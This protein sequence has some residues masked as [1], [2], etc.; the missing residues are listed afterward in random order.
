M[1]LLAI[2]MAVLWTSVNTQDRKTIIEN[3]SGYKMERAPIYMVMTPNVVRPN[4]VIQV[5]ATI[6]RMND[7]PYLDVKVSI[8]Q[9][10]VAY[11]EITTK[12]ERPGSRLMQM[13]MP[14]NSQKGHYRLRVEG[15]VGDSGNVFFNESD[16]GFDSKQASV[17]IQLSKPI[18]RQG[19]NVS[20]RVL[21]IKQNMMPKYGSMTIYVKDPTGYPVRRWLAVQTNAGGIV[22]QSFMLSDQPNYGNWSIQV[23]GYGFTYYKYF[24]VEEFW[25]PRFDVNVTV[26]SYMMENVKTV[27]GIIMANMTTGKPIEGNAS[28]L[29]TVTEPTP[30][31]TD[32]FGN[33]NNVFVNNFVP[34]TF[35]IQKAFGYVNGPINFDF[36]MDEIRTR[37]RSEFGLYNG[38]DGV[39]LRFNA[40]VYD[41]FF[42]MTRSGYAST[43]LFKS[44]VKLQ[45]VGDRVRTF[46][47]DSVLTVQVAVM[48]YDGTP[49]SSSSKVRLSLS[50]TYVTSG[51][52]PY[53]ASAKSPSGGIA[54]FQITMDNA[55]KSLT[56]QATWEGDATTPMIDMMAY[57]FYSP[58]NRYI[59]LST[60]TKNPKVNT[61]MLFHVKT[62]LYVPRIYYQ[63]VGGGNILVG[64]ELEMISR[65]KSFAIALSRDMV[66]TARVVVYYLS[67]QPEEIVVDS[68]TFFVDGTG[69]NKVGA[70]VNRG[71]DFTRDTVEILATA[72]KGAY[73]AFAAIPLDLYKR[74]LNDGLNHW[75]IIDELNTYDSGRK[76]WQHLW[77]M[78]EVE[79]Q[80]K[81]YTASGHGIDANTTFRD[82]G[83][84]VMSDLT[85]NRVPVTSTELKC[86]ED[87]EYLPCFTGTSCYHINDTCNM[88]KTCTQDWADEQNCPMEDPRHN[89]LTLNMINRVSRVL[90][91]YEDSSWAWKETFTKPDGEVDFRV[92]VPK[93]PLTWVIHGAS[94]SRDTGLGIQPKPIQYDATRYMYIIVECPEHIIRG[95]Q[96][97]VRVT[98]FNYWFGDEF[99]EV[100]VTMEGSP[101][102]DSVLVGDEGF[103]QSYAPRR[104]NGDHQTIVFLEPGESKDIFMPIVPNMVQ[105]NLTFT[106]SAWCFLERDIVS[107]TIY[108]TSDGVENFYHTPYLIDM[109]TSGSM[110]IPDLKVNV[111]DQFIV[112]EQRYH[113]YV[114]GS[115]KGQ[116]TVFGDVVTPGFFREFPTA[117]D[118]L[119]RPYGS[120]EMN[121][122]NFAYNLLTLKFKKANQ[123]LSNDVLQTSLK[124]M[125]IALQRQMGYMN[126]DGSFRMFRDDHKPSVWLTAFV[127][128]TLFQAKFGEWEK[129]FFIPLELINKM[130]LW[131]CSQQHNVTG[132]FNEL[133]GV[134]VYD[135][136]FGS[137]NEAIENGTLRAHPV[138]LTAYV[139]IA[140]YKIK[141]TSMESQ[142]C[143]EKAKQRAS[144]YL[145]QQVSKITEVFHLSITSYALSLGST[146]SRSVFDQLWTHVYTKPEHYFSDSPIR[147][148]PSRYVNTVLYL[149]PRLPLI[150]DGY[151]VQSTGYALL[152]HIN[153]YGATTNTDSTSGLI[154]EQRDS[155]MK[156][157]QTMRNT[158]AAFASTQDTLVAMDALFEFTLVDPNR[159]VF[160]MDLK[161]ESS[162]SP[163]WRDEFMMTK[164]NYTEM[165]ETWLPKVFGQVRV[166][167]KGTGRT[168]IQ[169]TTTVNVEYVWQVRNPVDSIQ[170][171]LLDNYNIEFSGRNF[172]TIRMTPCVS[173]VYE[174]RSK[175]SGLAVL[176]VDIPSGYVIMNDTLRALVNNPTSP[177]NL[178]RAEFYARKVVF[179]FEYLDQRQTCVDLEAHRWYPVANMTIQHKIRVYDYYEPGMH[180]TTLYSTYSLFNLNVCYVCGSYQCP[181]CPFF[182]VGA[183]IKAS[184]TL[185]S[186]IIGFVLQRYMLR[187]S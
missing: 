112:P 58:S 15:K 106:V 146:R 187:T 19:Q 122:F 151:A 51:S 33:N 52:F 99:I 96:V 9:D 137:L 141:D 108:I 169:L 39:E 60:S 128:K 75:T 156:W 92:T 94:M 177:A 88:I 89:N 176:E 84:L 105:G 164:E 45:W 37:L 159:N 182:N 55:L 38:Y 25:D 155:M 150:N 81:F 47:P 142:S 70:T 83:L 107:K 76:S 8:V 154:K 86:L 136:N 63:V 173:W 149:L 40:T 77:R 109:I 10:K 125:N 144:E 82:A 49:V 6:L 174:A 162:A 5:F 14:S 139:L 48:K 127:A 78:S 20:F 65:R 179:Y 103:V 118:I 3:T 168:L 50:P 56:I 64:E 135:R 116:V 91:F 85:V 42:R 1:W 43:I 66:P 185:I 186:L 27:G 180:N 110:I 26:K 97:G 28:V 160:S 57:R 181:Y 36:N 68:L 71:K 140:L 178:K 11:A 30:Q 131:L 161:L 90:R 134:P 121:M 16:I 111:S 171:F 115:P 35:T 114:P 113:Q 34:R 69:N 101:D 62:S 184:F 130:V 80:Y 138:P 152:A 44:G 59:T 12:F 41:W 61:Y 87:P 46:K 170:F 18:Y 24:Q 53:S 183:V 158:F 153:H 147:E 29:L 74:G 124:Y 95:E 21:P 145:S 157:L 163:D 143:M 120:A 23:D 129:E 32:V 73:I 93:Y 126:E 102:Y 22:S 2:T 31:Q 123:Q 133:P 67:G 4:E 7:Y 132:E 175:Q 167:V 72:D 148:N 17:F 117:E 98:V 54:E 100:L 166:A 104:H 119:Y 165:Q 79:Y 172:S 13:K